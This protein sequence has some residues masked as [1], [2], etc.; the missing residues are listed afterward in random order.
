M[1][2][3]CTC[4]WAAVSGQPEAQHLARAI[5]DFEVVLVVIGDLIFDENGR[6]ES[7]RLLRPF[8]SNKLCSSSCSS[9]LWDPNRKR[10]SSGR[11]ML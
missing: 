11:Y 10:R 7:R 6:F 5:Q 4:G 9:E 1:C 8:S 3:G 2:L